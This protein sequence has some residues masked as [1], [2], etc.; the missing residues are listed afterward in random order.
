MRSSYLSYWIAKKHTD[1]GRIILIVTKELLDRIVKRAKDFKARKVILFGSALETPEDAHDI[2]IACDIPGMD[3]F[4]F[5]GAVEE[6][7]KIPIDVI[8]LTPV[9]PFIEYITEF[10]EVIYDAEKVG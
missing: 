1:K 6:E 10:G 7:M 2:D 5:A 4:R 8:P 9:N 3:I